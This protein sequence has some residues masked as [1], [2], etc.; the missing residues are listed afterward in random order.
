MVSTSVLCGTGRY[1]DGK[2][3]FYEQGSAS[4]SGCSDIA[5]GKKGVDC[6][7]IY[8]LHGFGGNAK[9]L[10]GIRPELPQIADEKGIIFVCPDGKNSWYWDSPK[11]KIIATR[12]LS[13]Q[14]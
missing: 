9:T 6:P 10:I 5:L 11:N 7:V 1:A 2:K 3:P 4:G 13:L 14:K 12:L 8:L